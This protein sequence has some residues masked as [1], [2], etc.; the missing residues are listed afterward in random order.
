MSYEENSLRIGTGNF[1]TRNRELNRA[2]QG[3]FDRDQRIAIL[4]PGWLAV[5]GLAGDEAD[6]SSQPSRSSTK[7]PGRRGYRTG[8]LRLLSDRTFA[9]FGSTRPNGVAGFAATSRV[10]SRR[11]PS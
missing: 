11:A 5:N 1:F 3:I 7:L 2:D 10:L 8:G 6:G 9:R 4:V